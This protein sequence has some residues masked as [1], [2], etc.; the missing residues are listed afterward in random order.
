VWFRLAS[1]DSF[2]AEMTGVAT[3]AT[4]KGLNTDFNVTG[5]GKR[6]EEGRR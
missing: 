2:I 3:Y 4:K 6:K 1:N 5:R